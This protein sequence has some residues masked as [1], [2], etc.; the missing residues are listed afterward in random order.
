MKDWGKN[1]RK[2]LLKKERAWTKLFHITLVLML[3]FSAMTFSSVILNRPVS[4]EW[5]NNSWQ[6]KR[7][8]SIT[9][10]FL[11]YQMQIIIGKDNVSGIT[12]SCYN[13]CRDDFSDIRFVSG[14]A[15]ALPYWRQNYTSGV[16]AT[17]WV[18]NTYNDSSIY[19]YYGNPSA[20]YAGDGNTTFDFFDDFNGSALNTHKWTKHGNPTMTFS[21]SAMT[22]VTNA[23]GD[24]VYHPVKFGKGTQIYSKIKFVNSFR[25]ASIG[26]DLY[27]SPNTEPMM[28]IE[29]N[30][31]TIMDTDWADGSHYTEAN[32]FNL[33]YTYFFNYLQRG[34]NHIWFYN[35]A[36]LLTN[37]STYI[38]YQAMNATIGYKN[39]GNPNGYIVIDFIAVMKFRDY[40][41]HP[42]SWGS[43]GS[44]QIY[45]GSAPIN[46]Y[47]S[48]SDGATNVNLNPSLSITLVTPKGYLMDVHF[49]TN[50]SGTWQ[51]IAS[52]HNV[53]NGTYTNTT[54]AFTDYNRKY[55]WTVSTNDSLH[56][57]S[58]STYTFTTKSITT[59]VNTVIPY[60]V[61][62]R[63]EEHTSELQS[64]IRPQ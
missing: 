24:Y 13:H 28:C 15:N 8:L 58:N 60:N 34:V 26:Y 39:Y 18:N 17:F 42:P 43:S 36:T 12:A 63:S 25:G 3:I 32:N 56:E 21:N 23:A 30:G 55:W 59:N 52:Q 10:P 27:G 54:T 61:S 44:Q 9:N 4:A 35:N 6:Y 38:P 57:W 20:T 45:G 37:T 41:Q 51:T 50:A 53:G 48:P 2:N 29:T 49:K 40:T 62:N 16:K 11:Q 31:A 22:L 1:M 46:Q 47:P 33:Q 7:S 5:W 19:L 64:R 14:D